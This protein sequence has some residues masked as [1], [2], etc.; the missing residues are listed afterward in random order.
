MGLR[1]I[2]CGLGIALDITLRTDATAAIGMSRRLGVGKVRH[3]DTALLWVQEHV[4]SGDVKLHKIWGTEN[5]SDALTK[6]LSGPEL[7]GHLSKMNLA[8]EEGRASSAPQLATSVRKD[9]ATTQDLLRHER[10][11][12][13]LQQHVQESLPTPPDAP[14]A[15]AAHEHVQ[16]PECASLQLSSDPV[17]KLCESDMLNS[18]QR[19]PEGSAQLPN[20]GLPRA[21]EE[22]PQDGRV[23]PRGR[24]GQQASEGSAH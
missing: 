9:L 21:V 1:S 12:G 5:P 19:V 7:R 4:R 16:C 15:P 17:C 11:H 10:V 8:F 20:P 24:Q 2:A 22:Y 3:L 23:L 13:A 6:Y 18:G 14:V